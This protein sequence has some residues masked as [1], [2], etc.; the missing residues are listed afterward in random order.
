LGTILFKGMIMEE[1]VDAVA[2]N[3]VHS[4]VA[5]TAAE[6]YPNSV[7]FHHAKTGE[8]VLRIAEDGFYVRGIRVPVDENE[9][10][11]VYHSFLEWMISAKEV[12]SESVESTQ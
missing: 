8:P 10:M 1:N 5:M 3:E 6:L 9:A 4:E 11:S 7:I 12:S 2:I